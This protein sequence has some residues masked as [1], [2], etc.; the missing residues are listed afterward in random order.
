MRLKPCFSP[1][2][3]FGWWF[4]PWELRGYWSVH[5]VVPPMGLQTPSAP[6]VLS[7]APPL[8]TLC[9]VQG[10]TM[11]LHFCICQTLAEPLRKQQYQAPVS[12]H[13]LVSTIVCAF[14]NSFCITGWTFLRFLLHTF[15]VSP[16]MGILS[17][18]LRRTKVSTL[19]SSLFLS[20][21]LSVNCIL[22]IL[23]FWA[24]I[25]LSVSAYHMCSFVIGLPHS[26]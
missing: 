7:L 4:G 22:G 1:C 11:S 20:F 26:G 18:L 13:P 19:W 21:K 2:V 9:S 25:H 24:N 3:L 6:W 10:V 17:P 8:G 23:N 14:G 12:K 15:S 5:I 16:P